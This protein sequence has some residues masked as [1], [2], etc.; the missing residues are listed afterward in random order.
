MSLGRG[1]LY[2]SLELRRHLLGFPSLDRRLRGGSLD[3]VSLAFLDDFE[4][5]TL[6][7]EWVQV[8]GEWGLATIDERRCVVQK[9]VPSFR[10][11]LVTRRTVS[12]GIVEALVRAHGTFIGLV[13]RYIDKN[14]FYMLAYN[15]DMRVLR[16][17][18]RL[19][20]SWLTR[21]DVELEYTGWGRFT[22]LFEGDRVVCWFNGVKT[23]DVTGFTELT[24]GRVGLFTERSPP[25]YFDNILLYELT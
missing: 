3:R 13:F 14:N 5:P 6:N 18:K 22:V 21:W 15:G 10:G 25:Y 20:G 24:S 4:S 2:G 19:G 8:D 16:L 17:Q 12:N 23:H 1:L 7:P 9:G 11:L